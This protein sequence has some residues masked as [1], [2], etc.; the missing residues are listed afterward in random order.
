MNIYRLYY[1]NNKNYKHFMKPYRT[2]K[3]F[4]KRYHIFKK[5]YLSCFNSTYLSQTVMLMKQNYK[6]LKQFIDES[7][8]TDI[9]FF[10]RYLLKEI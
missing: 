8:Y 5:R 6:I 4:M 9:Q 3:P 7:D 10:V 2:F 1:H